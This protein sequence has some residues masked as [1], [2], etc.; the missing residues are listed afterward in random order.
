[1][2]HFMQYSPAQRYAA[3]FIG[4]ALL[5]ATVVGSGIMAERLAGGN[6]TC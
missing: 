1:M 4:T 3:E 2:N 5:L 6:G